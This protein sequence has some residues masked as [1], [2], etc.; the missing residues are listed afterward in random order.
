MP[1]KD[2]SAR[3]RRELIR[4]FLSTHSR[5]HGLP[6][7]FKAPATGSLPFLVS[8]KVFVRMMLFRGPARKF[9]QP[10]QGLLLR[11]LVVE[12][13]RL[14]ADSP[15]AAKPLVPRRWEWA[16]ETELRLPLRSEGA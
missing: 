9:C 14:L 7:S 6:E 12:A 10:A 13:Q 5:G 2:S 4:R 8:T 3:P 15:P 1:I 11:S 16:L